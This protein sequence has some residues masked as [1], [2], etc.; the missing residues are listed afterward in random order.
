M[1]PDDCAGHFLTVVE[2][3]VEEEYKILYL[4][5]PL[6][7]CGELSLKIIIASHTASRIYTL[8]GVSLSLFAG[9]KE[10]FDLEN[11]TPTVSSLYN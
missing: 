5:H 1:Y 11:P 8:P 6:L 7:D 10:A 2:S 3:L 9:E 4:R